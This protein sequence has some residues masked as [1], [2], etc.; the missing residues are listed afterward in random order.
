MGRKL[1]QPVGQS[2]QDATPNG[3]TDLAGNVSEWT[4]STASYYL[5]SSQS[6]PALEKESHVVR[7]GSYIDDV[8]T[9]NATT[10]RWNAD[11]QKYATIGFRL[12]CDVP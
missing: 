8:Q 6:V 12:A 1:P 4:S 7:G 10:R 11:L 3:I 5:G 2:P 9:I